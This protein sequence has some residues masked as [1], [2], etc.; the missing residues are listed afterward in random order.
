MNEIVKCTFYMGCNLYCE[1]Y[2]LDS[3]RHLHNVNSNSYCSGNLYEWEMDLNHIYSIIGSDNLR[4]FFSELQSHI[5]DVLFL[6]VCQA[7]RD[8]IDVTSNYIVFGFFLT[9]T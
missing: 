3:V 2:I 8:M 9:L 1:M 7:L 6:D 5:R 4:Y